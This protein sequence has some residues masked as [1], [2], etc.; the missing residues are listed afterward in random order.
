MLR[1]GHVVNLALGDACRA[2]RAERPQAR[3]SN[4]YTMSTFTPQTDSEKDRDATRRWQSFWN[5]WHLE[6]ALY[7]RYPDVFPGGLP[8]E[9]LGIKDGDMERV[10]APLDFLGLTHYNRFFVSTRVRPRRSASRARS[11]AGR[12][13]RSRRTA[14][15]SGRA[16]ST[17][18]SCG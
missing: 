9:R 16:P 3:L 17:T 2:I 12:K 6:P 14:G 7:G 4:A 11:A 10:K 13:A 5:A 1:A 18:S 15:R 8:A